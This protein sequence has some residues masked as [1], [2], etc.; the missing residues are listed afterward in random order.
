M[1]LA[2]SVSSSSKRAARAGSSPRLASFTQAIRWDG[3]RDCNSDSSDEYNPTYD[4][5]GNLTDDKADYQYVYDA[6]NRLRKIKETAYPHDLVAEFRYNG[7]GYKIGVHEDADVDNDVDGSDP[8]YYDAFDERWRQVARFRGSDGKPKEE[9][10]AH[11][12]G[13]DGRGG[14]SYIDLVAC[15]YKDAD[16]DWVRDE[17]DG[18]LEERLYYCQNWRADVTAIVGS[19]GTMKEWVNYSAYGI[20]YLLPAGDAESNGGTDSDDYTVVDGWISAPSYDVRGD[21]DLD[22]DLDSDDLTTIAALNSTAGGATLLSVPEISNRRGFGGYRLNG[23]AWE[24]RHRELG[25]AI[26]HWLQR[27]PIGYSGTA[28]L[29]SYVE[30]NPMG[31]VDPLGLLMAPYLVQASAA[32][33]RPTEKKRLIPDRNPGFGSTDF[34]PVGRLGGIDIGV[35]ASHEIRN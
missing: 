9:F 3:R 4:D 1:S 15:R 10:V 21:V 11:Q 22:G 34:Y 8:W 24:S 31:W 2:A 18:V 5:A 35:D 30:N 23:I 20:S 27:D 13:N 7:L 12:A 32:Q 14:S 16:T 28:S 26:G 25:I 33:S 17:S 6:F 29:Y 19:D